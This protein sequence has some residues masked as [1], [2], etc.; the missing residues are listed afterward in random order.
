MRFALT[1]DQQM[2]AEAVRDALD[3]ACPPDRVRA[4]WSAPD[5]EIWGLLAELGVL[6]LEIDPEHGGMGLGPIET[7][8]VLIECGRVAFPGPVVE[9]LAAAPL[10]SDLG[11]DELIEGVV[12]G[13]VAI[14]AAIAG[15]FH[16]DADRAQLLLTTHGARL[17]EMIVQSMEPVTGVDRARRLFLVDGNHHSLGDHGRRLHDRCALFTAAFLVGLAERSL[18]MAVDYAKQRRQFGKPIGAFQAVQHHLANALLA[19]RFAKPPLWRA[20]WALQTGAP[21]AS[22]A[23]SAAKAMASDASD[24]VTR[25]ALQVH[26]AIGYTFEYDLHLFHKRAIALQRAWGDAAWHRSRIGD[27]LDLPGAAHA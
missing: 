2:L 26:G 14:S 16:P 27:A 10:L 17:T 21:D 15:G 19:L 9:T 11:H 12:S 1:E 8:A 4:A 23:V 20:A 5:H 6:G 22:Q 18:D 25:T 13:D 24:A 7:T 3:D